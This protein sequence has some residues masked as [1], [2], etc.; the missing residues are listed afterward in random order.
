MS[1]TE[2]QELTKDVHS[3]LCGAHIGSRA[4]L[5]KVVRQ[6]SYSFICN[7]IGLEV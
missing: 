5:G 1:R 7:R 6:G 2:G 4:L 3:G